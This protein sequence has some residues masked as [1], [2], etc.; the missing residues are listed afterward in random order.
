MILKA[1]NNGV[2]KYS[3]ILCCIS[4]FAIDNIKPA[5][6]RTRDY[7]NFSVDEFNIDLSQVNC[8]EIFSNCMNYIDKLFS[9]FYTKVNKLGKEHAP[10]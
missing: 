5:G 2:N 7:S 1:R 4:N 6:I 10:P 8:D 9:S 3:V